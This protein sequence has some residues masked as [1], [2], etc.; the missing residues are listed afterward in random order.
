MFIVVSLLGIF[1][2]E[3]GVFLMKKTYGTATLSIQDQGQPAS[4]S[5][6]SCMQLSIEDLK[7]QFAK[8]CFLQ[9]A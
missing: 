8:D 7:I 4:P 3:S 9:V 5:N 1:L 6:K 2:S